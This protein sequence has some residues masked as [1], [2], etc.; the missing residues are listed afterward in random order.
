[1]SRTKAAIALLLAWIAVLVAVGWY[2]KR[3][4]VVGTDLRLFLPSPTTPEQRLLLEEIGEGPASR[5]LAIA[6]AGAAPEVLADTSRDFVAALSESKTFRMVANGEVSLDAIPEKLL[7]YRYLLSPTFDTAV[8]DADFLHAQLQ[9]RARDLASPAGAMLEPLLPRDPTLEMVE[10]LQNWQPVREPNRLYDVWFDAKGER[11]LLLA[12]TVAPAFDPDRQRAA[13]DELRQTF[14]TLDPEGTL[15][16]AISGP[17]AFSVL[18]ESRTRGE[19]QT[20]GTAATVGMIVLLLVAYR[21]FGYLLVSALPL[22]SAGIAG[23]LAVSVLYGEVHGI[24]LAFGFTLIGVAQDYPM[25][26]LSHQR[27]NHPPLQ[28]VRE[29]WPTLATGVASTCIA[30]ATF[31]FSGVAGLAQLACFTVTALAVAGLSTRFLLPRLLGTSGRDYG[32]SQFL[33]RLWRRIASLPA[34]RWAAAA[35]AVVCVALIALAPGPLWENDLSKLTPVPNDLLQQDQEVR[36]QL[37][38]PDLRYLLVVETDD[39]DQAL[40]RLESLD[41]QLQDLTRNGAITDFDHAAR[42]LPTR[43]KQLARQRKLPDAPTLTASLRQALSGTPFRV[44][45]FEPFLQDVS[46]ARTLSP[47][48]IDALRETPLGTSLDMLLT[49]HDKKVTALVTFAGVNDPQALQQ[50]AQTLGPQ[51]VLLDL[52]LASESLVARQ[53]TRLLWSLSIA[54]LL[55]IGVV[56]FALRNR[57]RVVR[58]LAPMALTTLILIAILHGTGVAMNLFHLIALILAAGLG[59][60]YALFFE[61]AADDPHDQRRTLHAVMVCSLST[62]MVFALLALS[63]L[64]VLRAIGMTVSLG[65]ICNFVLALLLT[66]EKRNAALP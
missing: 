52:K 28:I 66:R 9:A 51:A 3:D 20:L 56:A 25:H 61:H 6:I 37:G 63:T 44:D 21:S 30:Y 24:T 29:L 7:P 45:V 18:M 5:V 46:R 62:L 1:M 58:V 53:R 54:A 50:F 12:E 4:L 33:G 40:A 14:K 59:L 43:E 15:Q 2:V 38:T 65:V 16:L 8:M 55:L 27:P 31:L 64:P 22:A 48:S 41:P 39:V 36:S 10:L 49:R 13:L 32:D 11:A 34:P 60:D 26:L 47:L 35:L 42:Y 19:A 57:T 23:L 17:G